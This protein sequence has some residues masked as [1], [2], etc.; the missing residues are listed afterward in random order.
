MGEWRQ[1]FKGLFVS[2]LYLRMSSGGVQ[3][4]YSRIRAEV[5]A[6]ETQVS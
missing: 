1:G 6:H 3:E 2:V 4:G 5:A